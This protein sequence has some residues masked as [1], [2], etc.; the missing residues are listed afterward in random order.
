MTVFSG[1][2]NRSGAVGMLRWYSLTDPR[3]EPARHDGNLVALR[4]PTHRLGALGPSD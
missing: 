3:N 2:T 4:P 1:M